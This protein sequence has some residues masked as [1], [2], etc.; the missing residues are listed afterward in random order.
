MISYIFKQ[1]IIFNNIQKKG[2]N[3]ASIVALVT[4]LWDGQ[5]RNCVSFLGMCKRLLF[6]TPRSALGLTQPTIK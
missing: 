1:C 2:T 6:K 3:W 4:R 5:P